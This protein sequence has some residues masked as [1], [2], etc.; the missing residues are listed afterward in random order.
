MNTPKKQSG[1]TAIGWLVILTLIVFL[2]LIIMRLAPMYIENFSV[3]TS[4]KSLQNEPLITEKPKAEVMKLLTR[5]LEIN[6]ADS[7]KR[8]HI[9]IER[10]AGVLKIRI[11]YERRDPL[12]GNLD[13]VGKF[14]ERLE[15]ISN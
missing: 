7:V 2:A 15:I 1:V 14:D 10:S 9:D 13:V 8:S 12:I 5:R 6:D 4:L 3:K 11:Q